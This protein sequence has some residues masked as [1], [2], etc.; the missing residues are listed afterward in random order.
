M[1][2]KDQETLAILREQVRGMTLDEVDARFRWPDGKFYRKKQGPYIEP[3][4]EGKEPTAEQ[5]AVAQFSEHL[6]KQTEAGQA[7]RGR[8][9]RRA[10]LP[11]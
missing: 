11:A 2:I 9:K 6:R 5:Q 10:K 3:P 4:L 1:S 7:L 8:W